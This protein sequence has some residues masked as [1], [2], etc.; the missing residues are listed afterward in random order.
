MSAV[1]MSPLRPPAAA[2]LWRCSSTD[3][4]VWRRSQSCA[5]SSSSVPLLLL[6]RLR[7]RQRRLPQ[8]RSLPHRAA[9]AAGPPPPPPFEAGIPRT[10]S[11]AP[12]L[13]LPLLQSRTT[14]LRA[15]WLARAYASLRR[16]HS[17]ASATRRLQRRLR[18]P[19]SP[20]CC[21][22]PRACSTPRRRSCATATA[23]TSRSGPPSP[24]LA[25]TLAPRPPFPCSWATRISAPSSASCT[26][27][28]TSHSSTSPTTP[29]TLRLRDWSMP[30]RRR[31]RLPLLHA[32]RSDC[33]SRCRFMQ[34][35][36]SCCTSRSSR[37]CSARRRPGGCR[38][39]SRRTWPSTQPQTLVP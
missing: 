19:S 1:T 31:R 22:P 3:P 35:V 29:S 14:I 4:P 28:H 6:R 7:L 36:S 38:A 34:P 13:P 32:R 24:P 33:C 16:C 8:R 10:R 20:H 9:G 15:W 27:T 21:L 12:L 18:R 17:R 39:D 23:P 26:T 37:P 25:L 5:C 2:P 11:R 30:M